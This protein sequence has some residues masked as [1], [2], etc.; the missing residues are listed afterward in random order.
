MEWYYFYKELKEVLKSLFIT[1]KEVPIE[2]T[3]SLSIIWVKR[4]PCN[5]CGACDWV[6]FLLNDYSKT[7][8]RNSKLRKTKVGISPH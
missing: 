7:E 3:E 8:L 6:L 2:L 1:I 4:V 5:T